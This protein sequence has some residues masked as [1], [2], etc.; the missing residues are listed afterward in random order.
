MDL[1]NDE[2]RILFRKFLVPAVS[3]AVALAIY[4]FVDTIVIGQSVG[5]D[6]TAACAV[7]LPIFM[8]A[9][10]VALLCGVGGSVFMSKARGEG[11]QEK[12]LY[13]QKEICEKQRIISICRLQCLAGHPQI[14][15]PIEQMPS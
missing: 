15:C 11:R 8:I 7:V 14:R 2:P 3:S 10:F 13:L 4:S 6:G 9:G 1:L 5:A 12:G